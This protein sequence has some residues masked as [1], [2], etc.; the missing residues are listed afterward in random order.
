MLDPEKPLYYEF[1]D[2]RVDA[3]KHLLWR[4]GEQISLTPKVFETLLVFLEYRDEALDKD[5]LMNLLWRDSFVAESN[6]SQN[7]AVLRKVLG[8]NPKQ[9]KFILTIPGRGYRFVADVVE[10]FAVDVDGGFPNANGDDRSIIPHLSAEEF[11]ID[12]DVSTTKTFWLRRPIVLIFAAAAVIALA[13]LIAFNWRPNS[14]GGPPKKT[15]IAVLPFTPINTANRDEIYEIG[16]ADSLILKLN[17]MKGFVVRPL[18]ETRNYAN[19]GQDPLAAGREQQ[20]DYVLVSNYQMSGGK[21][22]ITSQLL[23]VASGQNEDTYKFE[24]DASNIF[25]MQDAIAGELGNNLASRFAITANSR[26]PK[27][28]TENEEAYRLY[29]QGMYLIGKKDSAEAR[30]AVEIFE[31]AVRLDPNYAQAW[32]GMAH[33][34]RL[35]GAMGRSA[36]SNEE[37]QR[38]IEA[39]NKALALNEDLA[40]AHS[41]LCD[42]KM[43]HEWDWDGAE[44][45]CKRAIELEPNSALA[46]QIYARH[47]MGRGRFDESIAE[48]KTAID[49]EPTS[50]F[51]QRIYG[52]CLYLARRYPE[53]VTQLK[54]VIAMDPNFGPTY[55]FL[56]QS[57]E[58]QGNYA[59]AFEWFM[60]F[61]VLQKAVPE[62]L[63]S[64]EAAYHTSDWQG[65]LLERVKR[66]EDTNVVYYHGAVLNAKA[67]NKDKAFE[68]LEKSY[69]RRELWMHL[70][71]VDPG[72][73]SL[74][75]DPR[76]GDL[77]RR[78]ESK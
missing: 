18:S 75:D 32:A 21:I 64:Y 19:V 41:A 15:T 17:S 42:N 54:R 34:H 13:A 11:Q 24:K 3:E 76:Y 68:Y 31:Q 43:Q 56:W 14:L 77:V 26:A 71:K 47:L 61:Q 50:L 53:A 10:I 16:I 44:S 69:Q 78:V 51:S 22:R 30:K 36:N 20:V 57:L 12:P 58:M 7:V 52:N 62:T 72:I 2:F 25:A 49:L 67:G 37:Y 8:E 55:P 23:N 73:D 9:H 27:H 63:Q 70:L 5:R 48:I 74:R 38:S 1:A 65:V 29:L 60:K 4:G 45:E 66:F 46:H 33:A 59:E 6:L 39:I 28:G 35:I 40:D